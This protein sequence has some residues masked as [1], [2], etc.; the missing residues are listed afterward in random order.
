MEKLDEVVR[1]LLA[2]HEE[3]HAKAELLLRSDHGGHGG[4]DE[5]AEAARVLGSNK[6]SATPNTDRTQIQRWPVPSRGLRASINVLS[7]AATPVGPTKTY[8][9]HQD[10][11]PPSSPPRE[12]AGNALRI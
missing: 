12:A 2:R 10:G 5:N 6:E 4:K 3:L 11:V 7:A 9:Q 8:H 1:S